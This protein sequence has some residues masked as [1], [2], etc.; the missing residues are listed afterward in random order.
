MVQPIA[1]RTARTFMHELGHAHA[2]LD[3]YSADGE[4]EY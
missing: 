4:R 2:N 3:E 1:E